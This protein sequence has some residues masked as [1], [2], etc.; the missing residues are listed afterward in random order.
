MAQKE[1]ELTQDQIFEILSS[2][3]RRYVLY[4]L[5]Q[6]DGGPIELIDLARHVAAW[7]ND[8]HVDELTQ[9]QRKR[10]YVSLYQSHIPKL[11]SAGIVKYD[12]DEG[13]VSLEKDAFIVDEY[14]SDGSR[15]F[16]WQYLYFGLAVVSLALLA[17]SVFQVGVFGALSIPLVAF[18]VMT[19]FLVTAIVHY[20]EQQRRRER[21]PEELGRKE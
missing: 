5:R 11:D 21:I 4:Y 19:A 3:R 7:E 17:L 13:V 6:A 15:P 9:Q 12:R 14:L 8:I 18:V 16:P 2:A 20:V 1:G 10:V